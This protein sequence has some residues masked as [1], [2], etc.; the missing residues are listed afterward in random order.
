MRDSVYRVAINGL[1]EA[2]E[3]H[4]TSDYFSLD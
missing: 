3:A 1:S 2:I 4:G